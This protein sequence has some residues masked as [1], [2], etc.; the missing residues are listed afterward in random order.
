MR[1]RTSK[2]RQFA[3]CVRNTGYPASLELRKIYEVLPD[4]DGAAHGLIRVIHESGEDHLYPEKF[5][6]PIKLPHAVEAA[7]R[8]AAG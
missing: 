4:V 5:F 3:V 2:E 7:V 6:M 8:R 1:R